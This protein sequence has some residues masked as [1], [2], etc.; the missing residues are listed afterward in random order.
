MSWLSFWYSP[1]LGVAAEVAEKLRLGPSRQKRC[2]RRTPP[3]PARAGDTK[4]KGR[5]SR[6]AFSFGRLPRLPTCRHAPSLPC[7]HYRMSPVRP[8]HLCG[9]KKGNRAEA[10][11]PRPIGERLPLTAHCLLLTVSGLGLRL[12]RLGGRHHQHRHR[13]APVSHLSDHP[14]GGGADDVP[15]DEAVAVAAQD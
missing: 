11:F 5:T 4:K 7:R 13:Q 9:Q 6:S 2:A 10:R 14:L 3:A 8:N 1:F 15:A 12:R